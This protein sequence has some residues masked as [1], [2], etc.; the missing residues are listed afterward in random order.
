[1]GYYTTY[2]LNMENSQ[3]EDAQRIYDFAKEKDMDFIWGFTVDGETIET[4]D[5]MKW[6][7]HEEEMREISRAFP[8]ILFKLHGEGE[9]TG[10]IWNEYYRDGKMQRCNAEIIIPPFDE[11][12]LF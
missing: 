10:D 1:M 2:S 11:N 4:S 8:H 5:P 9:E 3:S 12:K 6:Y 7:E